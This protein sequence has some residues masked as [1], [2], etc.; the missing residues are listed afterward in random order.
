MR[1]FF[2]YSLFK[3]LIFMFLLACL[4]SFG[5]L[6]SVLQADF[7]VVG[8]SIPFLRDMSP[9]VMWCPTFISKLFSVV[10]CGFVTQVASLWEAVVPSFLVPW[11]L[12]LSGIGSL[13]LLCHVEATSLHDWERIQMRV[14]RRRQRR[15]NRQARV[16]WK[17]RRRRRLPYHLVMRCRR[18]PR[19]KPP[20]FYTATRARRTVESL[21]VQLRRH[22]DQLEEE[23]LRYYRDLYESFVSG[24]GPPRFELPSVPVDTPFCEQLLEGLGSGGVH[25]VLTNFEL[26]SPALMPEDALQNAAARI[27]EI[28]RNWGFY[29]VGDYTSTPL[30]FDTGAS[31]GVTPFRADFIDYRKV[32]FTVKA[33][34]S[35]GQIVG[36]GTVL[37]RYR[38]R[39][40]KHKFIASK[41]YHMPAADIRLESPQSVIRLLG[42]GK[43]VL[44]NENI[45]WTL[46]SGEHIDIPIDP[47]SNL[48]LLFDTYCTEPEKKVVGVQH[49]YR[50]AES[51]DWEY[52]VPVVP[53]KEVAAAHNE[54]ECS[55]RCCQCVADETNQNLSGPQKE[56]LAWHQ[57]LCLNMRDLQ[58]LMRP[59]VI[60]DQDGNVIVRRPPVIPTKFKSTKNLKP[61]HFPMSMAAKL[62]TAKNRGT[63]TSKSSAVRSK[64]GILARDKYEP[65]D[66]I[67]TDQYIVH[68]PGRIVSG[69]GREAAQNCYHGGT[70]YQDAASNLV[71]VQNQ[72][73]LGAGETVVGKTAFEDW[74]WNL[75]GV[76]AKHYHSDNGIFNSQLFRDDCKSKTQSQSFSGVGAKHQN[77]RAERTIQTISYWA[78]QMMVHAA[79]HWPRD[80]ANSVRLWAFAIS[81]AAWLYNRLPNK[82]LGWKSPLE[83]FTKTKSDHRELLR[84]HVWGCPAFVL[85]AKLQDGHKLPKFNRRARMGQFLGY[86]DEH[87]TL[88]ARV[89][90]LQTNHVSPQFH[91]V[92][93]DMFSTIYNDT[94][95]DDDAIEAIFNKL[96]DNDMCKERYDVDDPDP[97]EGADDVP[98]VHDPELLD[99]WLTEGE[100]RDKRERIDKFRSSQQEV[101]RKKAEEFERLNRD[102]N[103][104]YPADCESP[105]LP[106]LH[107]VSDN[108]D[109]SDDEYS[110]DDDGT[111]PATAPEGAG[112][113]PA[114]PPLGTPATPAPAL[115]RSRR[116][117]GERGGYEHGTRGLDRHP[118]FARCSA[119][120]LVTDRH[121]NVDLMNADKKRYVCSLG[122]KQ[123]PRAARLSR[124]KK[125]YLARL[126][127]RKLR[128]ANATMSSM[129]WDVPTVDALLH[130]DLARFVHFAAADCGYAGSME[131][132]TINWLHPL[133][134][135][136]KARG[137]D[138]D[139]PNWFQAMNGPFA[140]EYWEAACL[141]IETLERMESWEVVE[142][143]DEMNI[144][145]ST[146]AFKCKRYP[147]GLI[148]KFKARFCARG[149][150]QLEGIDYFET[151]APVVM[152]VTIRLLLILECLLGLVSKQG[153]VECAFLHAHLEPEEKVY[154]DMPLGF[155]QYGKGGRA[156]VLKLKRTLYGLKQSPRAFWKYMV[157]KLEA[158]DMKQ[159]ELDPCLFIGP[160]VIAV[161][162]VDDMLMW[163]TNTDHI[164]ALGSQLRD[165]GVML[166]EED[167]AAGFLG[168]KL[169][170]SESTGQ[171][172]MTQEG[173]ITRIIE[174]LGLDTTASKPRHTPCLKAP[175]TKDLDGDPCSGD[176]S[177]AS[178]VGML[179]YL[180]GH[181][182]P[183]IA[184]SVS[185]VARFTFAPKRS[186]EQALKLIGRYLLATRDKGLVMTPTKELN[187]DAYPDADFAGLYG[188]EDSLDPVCVRSRT[189]F[190][191]NVANCPVLWK[192]SLQTETATS[193]MQ[194]EVIAMSSCCR[195][196]MPIIDMVN[197]VGMAVGLKSPDSPKMHIRIHEDNAGALILAQ[198]IPPQFTPRSKHYAI[199]T[200]WFREQIIAR[201][202]ELL[203]I[204]TVEQLG[205][206]CTKCLPQATFEYLRKKL[207][208]W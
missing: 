132:L 5:G 152:W 1:Y 14:L 82:N 15:H 114:P 10:L 204:D 134:L 28:G 200:H 110:D 39:E 186:H 194:A 150:R 156:K 124:K 181:S 93:D 116:L 89:R 42:G 60:R 83:V 174:A 166:E 193:T 123:P 26:G 35:I 177:Y 13:V 138:A 207:M 48:P 3:I 191:I 128:D 188:Y 202:I 189:G 144:L 99:E 182:R 62:A 168:V 170:K 7:S 195:E 160:T 129:V 43:V 173:L 18:R 162:Y 196:L 4:P 22:E 59:Q 16:K 172:V 133:I 90:H 142:R 6:H 176:F 120:S 137:N 34:G 75:A 63:G 68:T 122:K 96:F 9:R 76:L 111:P 140:Q 190:V 201:G 135:A 23:D 127:R 101:Q 97:P 153:D 199:K 70:I 47:R 50:C 55:R 136:A 66:A 171:M 161:M 147:D 53:K 126:V 198:T 148:K 95:V 20:S 33:V 79:L 24:D 163:S 67:H 185:Q 175:L 100:R 64:E 105:P 107:P 44:I 21:R 131:H 80:G 38:T 87:S 165:N 169:L 121:R 104:P 117:R 61:E 51:Y 94:R 102:F 205:D 143:E 84:T 159:S 130:S 19:N 98:P 86:S 17:F 54:A 88:V 197:E 11:A 36:E 178:V 119:H 41:A 77:A 146:W 154:I 183:D 112:V 45:E 8:S 65:G 103:P 108:E 37:R 206:I 72:V 155:K 78:R 179:L 203:K 52:V 27:N 180:A 151:Y 145:P 25:D 29:K 167:D 187:V 141:E 113:P 69:Y 92:F 109:S 30:I 31:V 115:R 73:S 184:Y 149:D 46:P 74:I 49:M 139:N 2:A 91:V 125:E 164:Y 56:L 58:Q 158:C 12:L 81:H 85:E 208:G 40:G 71:R 106:D 57:K 192:S 32:N 157:E 118:E